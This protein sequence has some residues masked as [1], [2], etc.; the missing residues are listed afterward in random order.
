MYVGIDLHKR[1][2]NAAEVDDNGYVLK[3]LK[4]LCEPDKLRGFSNS[5]PLRSSIVIESSSTWYWAYRMLSERHEVVLSNP[6]QTKAIASAKV[7]TDKVD[8][9]M[10]A[11]LL[12]GGYIPECYVPPRE[13]MELRELVR[14]RA[15]LV[16]VRTLMKNS[17]HAYL[18]MYNVKMDAN[19]FTKDFIGRLKDI[20][21]PKID[22]YLHVIEALNEEIDKASGMIETQAE[23]NDY[24]RLLMTIPGISYYTALLIVSEIG[25]IGRFPD[26]YH[27]VSYAG[28]SPS[29]HS[30][31]GNTYH[32]GITKQGSPYLRWALNQV[33]WAHIRNEPDGTVAQFYHKLAKKKGKA[34]AV[35]AASAKLLKIVYWV[36]KEQRPYR[37]EL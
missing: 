35:V 32:G 28:L 25:D 10:L 30:S 22:G 8:A 23:G 21:D 4:V 5:L 33:T 20:G 13:T 9:L 37:K 11:N 29:T 15:K 36:L 12:R 24:A 2:L 27:L 18:L 19:P 34:S 7:K 17:I 1:Y 6:I 26:S 16:K 14:Y 31:G 3:E